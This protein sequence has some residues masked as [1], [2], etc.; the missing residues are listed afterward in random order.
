VTASTPVAT[1]TFGGSTRCYLPLILKAQ[2]HPTT[3]SS[4]VRH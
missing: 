2:V 4:T 3:M 1:P